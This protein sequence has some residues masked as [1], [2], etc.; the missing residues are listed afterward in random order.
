MAKKKQTLDKRIDDLKK[1]REEVRDLFN[2]ILGAIEILE[3]RLGIKIV[4]YPYPEGQEDHYDEYVIS[5]LKSAGIKCCPS[6]INGLNSADIDLFNLR[7][8]MVGF[9]EEPFPKEMFIGN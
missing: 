6:A 7:R 1:Q 8:I 2:R 3:N 9:N 5:A 4:H